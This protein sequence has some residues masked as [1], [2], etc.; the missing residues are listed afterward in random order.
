MVLNYNTK[1]KFRG[2]FPKAL[3]PRTDFTNQNIPKSVLGQILGDLEIAGF[4]RSSTKKDIKNRFWYHFQPTD[5]GS[6]KICWGVPRSFFGY[7]FVFPV[8]SRKSVLGQIFNLEDRFSVRRNNGIPK[9]LKI[10]KE[11]W[12]YFMGTKSWDQGTARAQFADFQKSRMFICEINGFLSLDQ[13][14]DLLVLSLARKRDPC[15]L[16]SLKF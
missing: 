2:I 8:R 12:L 15:I 16:V 7:A 5:R 13:F 6:R 11:I 14:D 4:F 9:P 10:L 1:I 3:E